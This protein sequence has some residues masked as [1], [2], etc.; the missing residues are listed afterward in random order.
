MGR[1]TLL[2]CGK[3][4]AAGGGGPLS[5]DGSVH[6]TSPGTNFAVLTLSTTKTNN[7]IYVASESNGSPTSVVGS[8]LGAFTAR[9]AG[10]ISSFW[11]LAPSILSSET[12]TL[13][14]SGGTSF[15]SATAFAVNGANT[16]SPFDVNGSVPTLTSFGVPADPISLST[17]AN[18][19]IIIGAYRFSSQSNPTAGTGFTAIQ[20]NGDFLLTE[21]KIVSSAQTSLPIT[22]GT[23]VGDT[24]QGIGDAIVMG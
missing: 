24:N 10:A 16:S 14:Y 15:I 19:T 13:T 23:G 2:G 4:P 20:L 3:P 22:V 17:T 1:L 9:S 7:I 5:L 11:I 12:I 6:G 21:Y 8:T 18:D